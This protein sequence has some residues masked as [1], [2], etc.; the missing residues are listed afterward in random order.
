M[1]EVGVRSEM[2]SRGEGG[3]CRTTKGPWCPA[4]KGAP[5][6]VV[7]WTPVVMI[8]HKGS[9]CTMRAGQSLGWSVLSLRPLPTCHSVGSLLAP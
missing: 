4:L 3:L 2:V 7:S 1:R 5:E 6:P 9:S 8:M